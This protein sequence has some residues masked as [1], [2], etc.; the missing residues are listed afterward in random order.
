VRSLVITL[1]GCLLA[2]LLTAA[3]SGA[4]ADTVQPRWTPPE[5]LGNPA[6]GAQMAVSSG[7]DAVAVW[8][9][10]RTLKASYRPH[11][12]RWEH[13]VEIGSGDGGSLH[14]F[15]ADDGRATAVWSEGDHARVSDR[16]PDG[17][18][19]SDPGAARAMSTGGMMPG[20]L[21]AAMDSAGRLVLT[22]TDADD[23]W[24]ESRMLVWRTSR[25]RWTDTISA[26]GSATDMAVHAGVAWL[27]KGGA[28]LYVQRAPVRREASAWHRVWPGAEVF[29]VDVA[30]NQR[31]DL[32]VV[33][34]DG[35]APGSGSTPDDAGQMHVLARS[36][37]GR[38]HEALLDQ[39][40][41]RARRASVTVGPHGEIGVTYQRASDG[42]LL[43]RLGDVRGPSARPATVLGH[44]VSGNGPASIDVSGT[45]DVVVTWASAG[46]GSVP[47]MA[48]HHGRDASW[49]EPVRIGTQDAA[50]TVPTV[51]GYPNGM[52][53]VMFEN[54]GAT[55]W[56][57]FVDDRTGPTTRMR[58][59]AR[60]FQRRH[61]IAVRW[62]T[63][64][65]QARL[66]DSDVQWRR[67]G[68]DGRL[69][70]WSWLQH[71]TSSSAVHV[72]GEDGR[73][74]CFRVRGRD[75]VGNVGPWSRRR[76]TTLPVDD[77]SMRG[78][79]WRRVRDQAAYD[80][81]LTRSGRHGV[82][83]HLGGVRA[84]TLVLVVRTCPTCGRVEVSHGKRNLGVFSLSS[85]RVRDKRVIVVARYRRMHEGRVVVRS[86]EPGKRIYVDGVVASR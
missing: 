57:D 59:P 51:H 79:G 17:S 14:A 7:G 75:R 22:Q 47:V 42:A 1:L 39:Q 61:R 4:A 37:G 83:L 10:G 40:G 38:W 74:Y 8:S 53:T 64:D 5:T 19:E 21:R 15:V 18:W 85:S 80:H 58:T 27:V 16:R 26:G 24:G 69:G 29:A 66:R 49:R 44:H 32:A 36:A 34:L 56:T 55:R 67:S 25:G 52:S 2:S 3:P 28:G 78:T 60:S 46:P 70:A 11:G 41:V 48:S 81:T 84:R 9:T 20:A 6:T 71:R 62:S 13:P 73:S 33:L 72:R 12:D 23:L 31:G 54:A 82:G 45:G 30:G 77:R 68:R 50:W 35:D 86:V 65:Q 76:C 43:V 63:T